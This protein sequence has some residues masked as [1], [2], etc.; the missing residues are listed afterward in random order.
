MGLTV[1]GVVVRHGPG[2]SIGPITVDVPTGALLGLVGPNASGKTTLMKAICGLIDFAGDIVV[3]GETVV[4]GRPT[5]GTGGMIEEPRFYGWLSAYDNLR[6]ACG[7]EQDRLERIAHVLSAVE[8]GSARSTRAAEM[9]QGMRQR[10][11]IARAL[12]GDPR[13]LLLDE[14]TNGLD[15]RSLRGVRDLLLE[16]KAR[17]TTIVLSSH[18]L[19]EVTAVADRLL[20]LDTGVAV[21]AGELEDVLAGHAS[22]ETLLDELAAAAT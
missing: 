6:V 9:S 13:V 15:R 19:G 16:L 11:G 14:P 20:V 4:P 17:G 1:S 21:A 5:P 8:L 3:A 12:L 2:T 22:L 10:L 18:M 7:G